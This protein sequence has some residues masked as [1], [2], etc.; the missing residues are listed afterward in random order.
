MVLYRIVHAR[1]EIDN[2]KVPK[3]RTALRGMSG[4]YRRFCCNAGGCQ[5]AASRF[6]RS[7]RGGLNSDGELG[8][9]D[10]QYI[11]IYY[12][13]NTVAGKSVSWDDLLN[14]P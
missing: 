12:T 6:C 3:A 5:A 1:K 14:K 8:I 13:E 10:A 7:I 4:V 2:D 11:L 9:E